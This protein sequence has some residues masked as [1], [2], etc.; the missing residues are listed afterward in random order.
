MHELRARIVL[1]YKKRTI[2]IVNGHLH[3]RAGGPFPHNARVYS[4]RMQT[5]LI[6]SRNFSGY[7]LIVRR[8]LFSMTRRPLQSNHFVSRE[9]FHPQSLN[10]FLSRADRF[11]SRG[12]RNNYDLRPVRADLPSHKRH[13]RA[14]A[15]RARKLFRIS[16]HFLFSADI[17][18]THADRFSLLRLLAD[19]WPQYYT[20]Q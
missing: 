7:V 14:F 15:Q 9:P 17:V 10:L 13:R 16:G 2:H 20:I 11:H 6:H 12:P 8:R 1:C 18:L 5:D 3:V 4:R 19:V